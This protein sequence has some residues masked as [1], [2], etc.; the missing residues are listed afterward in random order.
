MI[1]FDRDCGELWLPIGLGV[2]KVPS[3]PHLSTW[4]GSTTTPNLQFL[5]HQ[6]DEISLTHSALT[7]YNVVWYS[8]SWLG[9]LKILNYVPKERKNKILQ[10][11]SPSLSQVNVVMT[12]RNYFRRNNLRIL[13]LAT[14][15]TNW[16]PL[17]WVQ[18]GNF[19]DRKGWP[20]VHILFCLQKDQV[21]LICTENKEICV[22]NLMITIIEVSFLL[23]I[24]IWWSSFWMV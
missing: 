9:F 10:K 2:G 24:N 14:Y 4:C 16:R 11:F 22:A 7:H 17:F 19:L 8:N 12:H 21:L 15:A 20:N 18:I 6:W 13:K 3:S 23:R 1:N 5:R